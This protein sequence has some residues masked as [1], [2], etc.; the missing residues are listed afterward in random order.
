MTH[1]AASW[2]DNPN[3]VQCFEDCV[4]MFREMGAAANNRA[5]DGCPVLD[6]PRP[7][8]DESKDSIR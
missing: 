3:L 2:R 8:T 4:A 7:N 5:T 6:P 1:Q